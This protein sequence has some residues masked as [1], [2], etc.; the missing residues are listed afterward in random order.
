MQIIYKI[1]TLFVSIY[2]G[3]I[4]LVGAAFSIASKNII[5]LLVTLLAEAIYLS[6]SLKKPYRRYRALKQSLPAGW[7]EI[8]STHSLFYR[9][10]DETAKQRFEDDVRIFL[11][12]FSIKGIRG[13]E[14]DIKTKLLVASGVA[15]LLNGRPDWEPP[16]Q[17]GVLVYPGSTFNR[18]Y[19][20]GKGNRAGQATPNSPLIVTQDSLDE[21]FAYPGDGNNVVYHELAHYFDME[22]GATE[23]IPSSRIM[24]GKLNRWQKLITDEWQR[25]S[26]GY[27]FLGTYAGTN[28]AET[29]AVAVEVFFE[30]PQLMKTNNPELYD[31]LKEFFNIDTLKIMSKTD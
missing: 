27:S 2:S 21:S 26:R 3:L 4:L 1:D 18:D 29:F 10:L 9:N 13:S 22:D 8:L 16:I 31:A 23:G 7:R 20:I 12:D 14:P 17:D 28:E 19:V 6:I 5:F 11:S 24:P 15:T 25:A 30:T